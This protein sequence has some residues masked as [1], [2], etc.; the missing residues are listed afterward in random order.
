LDGG[1]NGKILFLRSRGARHL[2]P[3]FVEWGNSPCPLS[4]K[5]REGGR[6]VKRSFMGIGILFTA[7]LLSEGLHIWICGRRA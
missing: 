2:G 7:M 6:R 5:E 4:L 1:F 3:L